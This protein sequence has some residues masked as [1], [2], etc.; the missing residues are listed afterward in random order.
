MKIRY[1]FLK[2]HYTLL[3]P[4]LVLSCGTADPVLPDNGSGNGSSTDTPDSPPPSFVHPG[5]TMTSED[6]ARV[7]EQVKTGV[8]PV[9]SA[10]RVLENHP[11]SSTDY[12]MRG[13]F[14]VI[15][16]GAGLPD[17]SKHEADFSAAYC[18]ALMYVITGIQ[19]HA[20]KALDIL[21]QYSNVLEKA[22]VSKDIILLTGFASYQIAKTMELL[23]CTYDVPEEK[24]VS[25]DRMLE[26]KL[27]PH[28][29][30]DLSKSPYHIG[31]QDAV[32]CRGLM[33]CGIYL[34]DREMYD[35]AKNFYIDSDHNGCLKNY[36]DPETGQCQ[37]SGRD[38]THAQLGLGT[39]AEICEIA[40]KQGDDLYSAYDDLIL[41]G[42]EYTA[43]YNVGLNVPFKVMHDVTG[44]TDWAYKT[45]S[46]DGRGVFLPFYEYIFNH[47][48]YRKNNRQGT[49][50]TAYL[51]EENEG[52][53]P[54]TY[55]H[56]SDLQFTF[57]SLVCFEA[58]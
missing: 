14:S 58:D 40:W 22:D 23:C 13:P 44:R 1:N 11:Y 41:K 47:F 4:I 33:A 21:W 42:F 37:E 15:S 32:G 8:E 27:V 30:E 56:K 39:M 51:L 18:N 45:L 54:E 6:I 29:K 55:L 35:F 43:K 12:K 25:I 16:A 28:M 31:N 17:D 20:E 24:K 46:S 10:Y 50:M 26:E 7:R 38:Q 3:I 36:I 9:I 53:R 19:E 57:A 2:L 5:I 52:G 34:D 48:R 49:E